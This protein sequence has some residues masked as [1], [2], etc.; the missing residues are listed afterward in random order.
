MDAAVK[1]ATAVTASHRPPTLP[2]GRAAEFDDEPDDPDDP[3]EH[4]P[5]DARESELS[6]H[7]AFS[8]RQSL[9]YVTPSEPHTGA[10]SLVHTVEHWPLPLFSDVPASASL[11]S[12][13][14]SALP[15]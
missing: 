4:A 14:T 10:Y 8:N 7:C 9:L 13:P 15:L 5:L 6:R 12:S 11:A 1:H 3:D 2:P